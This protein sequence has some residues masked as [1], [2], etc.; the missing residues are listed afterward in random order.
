MEHDLGAVDVRPID[1]GKE[2]CDQ[3]VRGFKRNAS[4]ALAA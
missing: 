1:E 2:A 4:V 3:D